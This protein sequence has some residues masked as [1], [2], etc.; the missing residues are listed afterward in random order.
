M[1]KLTVTMLAIAFAAS[2]QAASVAGV[3]W[4]VNTQSWKLQDG[5]F[6]AQGTSMWL[7]D[8]AY[9]GDIITALKDKAVI[10]FAGDWKS[11][12]SGLEGVYGTDVTTNDKGA[13][14]PPVLVQNPNFVAISDVPDTYYDLATLVID[15]VS[16]ANNIYYNISF[17]TEETYAEY[18]PAPGEPDS[19][20]IALFTSDQW[21]NGTGWQLAQTQAVPE[22]TSGLLMLIG[23][24][25]LA[26]RRRRG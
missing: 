11:A 10:D 6:A 3:L 26:L 1:K 14:T 12:I 23:M 22:P 20:D 2:T 9:A 19:Y 18:P 25:G 17:G 5:T 7:I 8:N 15:N 13:L 16:N 24:A 4:N 21:D